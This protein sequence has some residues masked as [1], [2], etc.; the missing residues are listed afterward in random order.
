MSSVGARTRLGVLVSGRG[1][2]TTLQAFL[3]ASAAGA[4]PAE[5]VVVVS[6]ALG[7]PALDRAR[8]ADVAALEFDARGIPD[9]NPLDE[10]LLAAIGPHRPDLVCMAG[11]LRKLGP[12]FYAAYRGRVM[13]S[14]PALIPAFCGQGMYGHHVHEAVVAYGV[15]VSGCTIHF[16]DEEYDAGPI[17]IQKCVPVHDDDTPD[18]LAA[19]ILPEEHRAYLQAIRLFAEGRLSIE[20]RKVNILS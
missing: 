13:N 12:R 5:V 2:G 4:L 17:I 3:D 11:F 18:T 10:R 8:A 19:R 15:K 20:G 9:G 14:H 7:T 1:R 16:A 6:T